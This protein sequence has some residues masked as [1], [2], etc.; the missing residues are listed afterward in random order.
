M[1]TTPTDTPP[2]RSSRARCCSSSPTTSSMP[3][4]NA[5]SSHKR[6]QGVPKST[7]PI[8]S[9]PNLSSSST[10]LPSPHSRQPAVPRHHISTGRAPER[11]HCFLSGIT[12]SRQSK[13]SPA[14]S[15]ESAQN[16]HANLATSFH[17]QKNQHSTPSHQQIAESLR[18]TV[19]CCIRARPLLNYSSCLLD[20][21][22]NVRKH[23]ASPH[24]H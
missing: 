6:E 10:A 22:T 2:M 17:G 14:D 12:A 1:A 19:F 18:Q 20:S 5:T 4:L 15:Q 13:R 7:G 11:P 9:P 8:L 16:R 21:E 23:G 24:S 3:F